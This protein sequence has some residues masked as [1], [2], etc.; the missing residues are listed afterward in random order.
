VAS[1]EFTVN[2]E[3]IVTVPA[4]GKRMESRRI[5]WSPPGPG[6]YLI[7][8][9]GIDNNGAPGAL[10]TSLVTVAETGAAPP[11]EEETVPLETEP[12]VT[13]A[14]P[15][16][17]PPIET[18]APV[19]TTPIVVA[20]LDAN[21][22]EGPGTAYE[23]YGNLLEGEQA[24]IKGRLG[25]SS[26]FLIT[27][28]NRSSNCWIAASVVDVHG[29]PDTI[30][31]A[32]APPPPPPVQTEPPQPTDTTPPVY[33]AATN[34]DEINANYDTVTSN[35]IAYDEESGISRIYAT[36]TLTA[37]GN[38][39]EEG[40]AE[41][42]PIPSMDHAYTATFGPF[43]YAGTLVIQG[44]ILDNAGNAAYFSHTVTVGFE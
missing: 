25:D 13:E 36:W 12:P 35:V 21:C 14:P 23:V 30:Q 31:V 28:A 34:K 29:D 2:H 42:T 18:E 32:A 8:A 5:E 20:K 7:G 1:I 40:S 24:V 19:A 6:T 10:A 27:L 38:T 41:Y 22:R 11:Q 37:G 4:D 26:W 44:T 39:L 15:T 43:A 17:P 9:R 33:Q 3:I 16:E